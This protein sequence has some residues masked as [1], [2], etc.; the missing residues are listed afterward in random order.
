MVCPIG[1]GLAS[2]KSDRWLGMREGTQAL[3]RRF[4][5]KIDQRASVRILRKGCGLSGKQCGK[6]SVSRVAK[7]RGETELG[8][9]L[10]RPQV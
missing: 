7:R 1:S 8:G 3:G 5:K 10:H 4:S 6:F 2:R 9:K